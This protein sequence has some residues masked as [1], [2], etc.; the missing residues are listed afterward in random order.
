MTIYWKPNKY[1]LHSKYQELKVSS[2]T[3]HTI[4]PPTFRS[5]ANPERP[6]FSPF[7]RS[8]PQALQILHLKAWE[9]ESDAGSIK[10]S[11]TLFFSVIF[12]FF[13]EFGFNV[14]GF[15]GFD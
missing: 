3:T 9:R 8:P 14:E 6:K 12:F 1:T 2:F 7:P 15:K 5:T 13:F 4:L 10:S 11:K